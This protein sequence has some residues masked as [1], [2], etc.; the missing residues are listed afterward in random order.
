VL[1]VHHKTTIAN[2]IDLGQSLTACVRAHRRLQ[3]L[4]TLRTQPALAQLIA[5][6]DKAK[7]LHPIPRRSLNCAAALRLAAEYLTSGLNVTMVYSGYHP[8]KD[9][10]GKGTRAKVGAM[11]DSGT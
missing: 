7:A 9:V 5:P 11:L 6:T 2:T 4:R 3:P 1:I 10:G 8:H